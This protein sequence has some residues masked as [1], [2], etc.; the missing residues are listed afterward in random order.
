MA[1]RYR[2]RD[3]ETRAL[4]TYVKLMRASE[5]VTSRLAPLLER[6]GLTTSQFGVLEALLHVGPMCQRDLARKLL[7]S[8]GNIT[9]VVDNLEKRGLVRR[10]RDREDRRFITVHLTEEGRRLIRELFPRHAAA[11]TQVMEALTAEEL[12]ELGRL[13]KK[14][15]LSAAG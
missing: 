12:A 15:G 1:I 2:G 9:L 13:C 4:G 8:G 7:K 14:L 11:L 5:S 3:D 6:E 10:E